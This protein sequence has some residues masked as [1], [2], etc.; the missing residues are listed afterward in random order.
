[1]HVVRRDQDTQQQGQ[2]AGGA[3]GRVEDRA[4]LVAVRDEPAVGTGEQDR[5]ELQRDRDAEVE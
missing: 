1:M 3:L 5:Q 2:Q 4:L